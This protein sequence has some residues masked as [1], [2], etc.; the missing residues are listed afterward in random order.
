MSEPKPWH[1]DDDF[2]RIR[3]RFMFGPQPWERAPSQVDGVLALLEP[4][5]GAAVLDLGCGPGRHSLELARRGFRVTGVDR[6]RLY[7]DEACRRASAEDLAVEF[8]HEDMR[9]FRRPG[10]FDAAINMLTA[11]GYFDDP[12]DDRQVLANLRESLKPGGRLLMDLMGKEVL[13][14]I[15]RPRDWHEADGVFLLTE[16]SVERDWTWIHNHEVILD[17]AERWEADM[18]HRIYSAAELSALL[19]DVGFS[20]VRVFGDLDAS[21]YDNSA[22]RLILVADA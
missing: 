21:L 12:A 1:E 2:W 22:K 20:S 17:G 3:A 18:D 6:T 7:L 11:F 8:V 5:P 16:R 10:A 4:P 14:R 19:R 15:F 9:S 13:A